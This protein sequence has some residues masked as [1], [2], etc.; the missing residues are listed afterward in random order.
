MSRFRARCSPSDSGRDS[1]IR[2]SMRR[3]M[4][5]TSSSTLPGSPTATATRARA[6]QGRQGFADPD[7]DLSVEWIAARRAIAEAQARHDDRSPAV[8]HPAH[9]RLLAQRSHLPGRNV[10]DFP[11]GEH[12]ARSR[13]RRRLRGRISSTSAALDVR[14]RPRHLSL[15][16]LRLD[17]DAALPLAVLVLPEPR[18]RPGRTTG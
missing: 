16:G 8:A 5:S 7:Y 1:T 3:R 4:R 15:Q 11:A 6:P 13:R 14:I 12:G 10:E 18:A 9:Q 2:P 17:R